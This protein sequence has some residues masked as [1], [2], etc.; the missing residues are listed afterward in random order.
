M[1]IQDEF[2]M[3]FNRFK[4]R[5]P[6]ASVDDFMK[7]TQRQAPDLF[8]RF[9]AMD[10]AGVLNGVGKSTIKVP[11]MVNVIENMPKAPGIP[12]A[13]G[14]LGGVAIR[15][16]PYLGAAWML[17]DNI[18]NERAKE[19]S[20]ARMAKNKQIDESLR[21]KPAT[22][23]SAGANTTQP[24]SK[25]GLLD[26]AGQL[27]NFVLNPG[28]AIGGNIAS[29][30]SNALNN[31]Q[32]ISNIANSALG[33]LD[34]ITTGLGIAT[35]P[36]GY[37]NK[38]FIEPTAQSVL[39]NTFNPNNNKP[40]VTNEDVVINY[41]DK[42]NTNEEMIASAP[43]GTDGTLPPTNGLITDEVPANESNNNEV[44][45]APTQPI[46][47]NSEAPILRQEALVGQ[48]MAPV[49]NM[50]GAAAGISDADIINQLINPQGQV[51]PEQMRGYID[52][53]YN[54]QVQAA[55]RNPLYGG[56]YVQPGGYQIDPNELSRRQAEDEVLRRTSIYGGGPA[57]TGNLAQNY[58]DN[59]RQMYNAQMANRA[60][61]P[62]EDYVAGM[63]KRNADEIAIRQKQAEAQLTAYAQ[64]SNDMNTRLQVAQKIMQSRQEAQNKIAEIYANMERD[65]A[66]ENMKG[67]W[68]YA[69]QGLVNTG[70]MQ[71]TALQGANAM[72]LEQYKQTNPQAV[73]RNMAYFLYNAG[74]P[75]MGDKSAMA[76]LIASQPEATQVQMFGRVVTPQEAEILLNAMQTQENSNPGWFANFLN[77]ANYGF[78]FGQ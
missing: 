38:R 20:K 33:A 22:I 53:A 23:S 42:P 34:G 35:N 3:H 32:A 57:Y 5:F 13:L 30:V 21:N 50:T 55:N 15:S 19:E 71:Q 27:S 17:S 44:A 1:A 45:L 37:I 46:E 69:R 9:S 63:A 49:G 73:F 72:N 58:V 18:N 51:T 28:V 26:K 64:Q 2:N 8:R 39:T 24:T 29:Q 6:N 10:R 66:V 78:N 40:A 25:Q 65:L 11:N 74:I 48:Q 52:Q 56:E 12:P 4:T 36:M 14:T 43:Q 47:A 41:V 62:Y 68:D 77:P 67:K 16:I 54:A 7:F 76:R 59:Q 70:N 75:L 61:V 31:N 60:G